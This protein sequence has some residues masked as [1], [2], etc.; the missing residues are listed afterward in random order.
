MLR[1]NYFWFPFAYLTN[2]LQIHINIQRDPC[3]IKCTYNPKYFIVH[4]N[5]IVHFPFIAV[6]WSDDIKEYEIKIKIMSF[7]LSLTL[8]WI[9]RICVGVWSSF[10]SNEV[11][12]ARTVFKI[13][14]YI[15]SHRI[16]IIQN[17]IMHYYFMILNS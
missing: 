4:S 8:N 5:H 7:Q 6:L 3:N 14:G 15:N 16:F 2:G 9:E 12:H 17:H 13:M 10:Y 11:F 1:P